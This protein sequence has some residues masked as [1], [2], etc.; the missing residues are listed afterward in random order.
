MTPSQWSKRASCETSLVFLPWGR[1][2]A[3]SPSSS[4]VAQRERANTK[5]CWVYQPSFVGDVAVCI[6]YY[7]TP[8]PSL[9]RLSEDKQHKTSHCCT[10][11]LQIINTCI[12]KNLNASKPSNQSKGLDGNIDP[13]LTRQRTDCYS[14]RVTGSLL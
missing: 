7:R 5:L 6:P 4:P 1:N 13:L 11:I 10:A 2:K 3:S 14:Y 8:V 9:Y 12:K